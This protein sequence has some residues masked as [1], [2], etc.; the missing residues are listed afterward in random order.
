[1]TVERRLGDK[2][3]ELHKFSSAALPTPRKTLQDLYNHWIEHQ[4]SSKAISPQGSRKLPDRAL[5]AISPDSGMAGVRL[6]R[7]THRSDDSPTQSSLPAFPGRY[8]DAAQSLVAEITANQAELKDSGRQPILLIMSDDSSG[9]GL[10]SLLQDEA[11]R[12]FRVFVG[13]DALLTGKETVP[14]RS[15]P[16]IRESRGYGQAQEAARGFHEATF[17]AMPLS[18]RI[19]STKTFLRDLTATAQLAEGLVFTGSSN[20]GRL[21][22]MLSAQGRN[23]KKSFRSVDVRWFPTARYY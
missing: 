16:D 11:V 10:L 9:L 7:L 22:A 1:M 13:L 5:E 20:V 6:E 4:S 23:K 14:T 12:Q 15:E 8:V 19:A 17:N 2:A 21:L 18:M 3:L